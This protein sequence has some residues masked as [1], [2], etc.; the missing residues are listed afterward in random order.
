MIIKTDEITIST[1]GFTDIHDITGILEEKRAA[2]KIRE[3]QVIVFTPGSTAGVTTIE[4]E[5]GVIK[6]LKETFEK[7][8][9][10]NQPYHHDS[11]WGDG[12][13]FSH[14][15][16]A[17]LGPSVAIPIFDSKL[18]LGTWQQVI[19]VDFDNRPRS[20]KVILQYSGTSG[21]NNAD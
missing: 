1:Q 17:L 4:F 5:P 10:Q 8:V 2:N 14:V 16:S 19:V 3:G 9:P 11:R 21:A 13:G 6:D 12:N 15:R 20:R 7:L 18:S